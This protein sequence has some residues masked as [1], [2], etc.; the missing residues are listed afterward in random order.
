MKRSGI[1]Q[2]PQKNINSIY[3]WM[4]QCR[5][6]HGIIQ[7]FSAGS[8]ISQTG[9]KSPLALL[10]I[11]SIC[12]I[13]RRHLYIEQTL[14]EIWPGKSS[15][16][17]LLRSAM[18]TRCL[19]AARD[20]LPPDRSISPLK[21]CHTTDPLQQKIKLSRDRVFVLAFLAE[22]QVPRWMV[23]MPIDRGNLAAMR[24]KKK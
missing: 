8:F 23:C 13:Y 5:L 18:E 19:S 11:M 24:K 22:C 12:P 10:P 15:P 7:P 1:Q 17:H 14:D 16:S 20:H 9:L 4:C 2:S 6:V 3:S 21:N